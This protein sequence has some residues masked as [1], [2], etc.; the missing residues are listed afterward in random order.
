[1]T[2]T[3]HIQ[4]GKSVTF[5]SVYAPTMQRPDDE[6]EAFYEELCRIISKTKGKLIVMGD[7]NARVGKEHEVWPGVLVRHGVGKMNSN[8][9]LLL[10]TCT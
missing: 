4:P 3:A 2:M 5:I 7:F 10:E 6:K 8:G 1:M 9:L